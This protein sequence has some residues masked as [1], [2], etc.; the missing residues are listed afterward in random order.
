LCP[1]EKSL[2]LK[3]VSMAKLNLPYILKK[4]YMGGLI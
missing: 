2:A 4:E 3:M 1:G